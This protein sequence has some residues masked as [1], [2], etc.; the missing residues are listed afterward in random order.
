MK[1]YNM[2]RI[3]VDLEEFVSLYENKTQNGKEK[4]KLDNSTRPP[5]IIIIYVYL[6]IIENL[7]SVF[8]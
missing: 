8:V 2:Q 5:I 4:E 6:L 1:A 3:G 7:I